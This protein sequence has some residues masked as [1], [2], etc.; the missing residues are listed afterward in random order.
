MATTLIFQYETTTLFTQHNV[1]EAQIPQRDDA[2]TV[3]GMTRIVKQRTYV[4]H[5]NNT[6]IVIVLR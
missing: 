6:E 3:G 5:P 2:V 1:D 4:P